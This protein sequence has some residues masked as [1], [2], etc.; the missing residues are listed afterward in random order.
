MKKINRHFEI[1][2]KHF[3]SFCC[4]LTISVFKFSELLLSQTNIY[5]QISQ[6]HI[7]DLIFKSK[8]KISFFRDFTT[9][10]LKKKK[11]KQNDPFVLNY[12]F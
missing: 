1:I 8:R 4:K 9:I 2:Q 5:W 6:L 12:Y 3:F 10:I 7:A 11:T